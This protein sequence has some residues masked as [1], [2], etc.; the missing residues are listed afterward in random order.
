VWYSRGD[1]RSFKIPDDSNRFIIHLFPPEGVDVKDF[2]QLTYIGRALRLRQMA[3]LALKEYDLSVKRLRLVTNMTNG[4]FRVDTSDGKKYMLRITDPL[5]SHGLEEIR[6]EMMWLTALRKDTELGV[7]QPMLTQNGEMAIT[8]KIDNVPEPRHCS[9]FNWVPGVNAADR[10]SPENIHKL[11]VFT[12]SLHN[13]AETF[14]PPPGFRIRKLDK[15]FPYSDPDFPNVEPVV[16][17]DPNY[18]HLF[19]ERRLKIYRQAMERVQQAI[20]QLYADGGELH[21]THND[22]HQWNMKLYRGK[23]FVLDFEDLAWGYPVQDIAT[24]FFYFQE[25]ELRDAFVKAYKSGYTT[26]HEWPETYPGQIQT[27]I[28][29]RGIMLVNYLL[30]SKNSED[31]KMASDYVALVE[32]RLTKFLNEL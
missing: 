10:L 9:V 26:H 8:V 30:C 28:A 12:A 20:D 14:S 2:Y 27:F 24:T 6:S 13:H 1:W 23:L 29:G 15:I 17:F 16:I 18:R 3:L 31:Q 11:G 32:E 4:I 21:V 22:L 25:N 7:P 5:G 19:P